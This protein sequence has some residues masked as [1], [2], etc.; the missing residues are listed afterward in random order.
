M[1]ENTTPKIAL[2]KQ[3][4]T[5]RAT[6]TNCEEVKSS[7]AN[8]NTEKETMSNA[9]ASELRKKAEGMDIEEQRVVI[10]GF[11]PEVIGEAVKNMLI[12]SDYKTKS[13]KNLLVEWE[14]RKWK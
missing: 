4:S 9:V 1:K 5:D 11:A 12:E 6:D 2:S 3:P 8:F 7:L 13:L 10:K 14:K